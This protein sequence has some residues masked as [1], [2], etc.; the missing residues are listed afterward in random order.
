VKNTKYETL[1]YV[2]ICTLLVLPYA[3][4]LV[5][6]SQELSVCFSQV[7]LIENTAT[8]FQQVST[9]RRRICI[10]ANLFKNQGVWIL[11][12]EDGVI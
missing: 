1:R 6:C 10:S 5:L 9:I 11:Q 2:I 4:Y 7:M 3:A 8:G 12:Q